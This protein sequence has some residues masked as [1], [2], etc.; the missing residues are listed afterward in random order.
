MR[1]KKYPQSHLVIS[2]SGKKLIIDP[3]Y[4]TF[5]KG[6]KVEDFQGADV[7]L[8]THQH[9]DHLG[10]ETIRDIVGDKP[11]LG[12]SDVIGK[13]KEIGV[14]NAN[15][16]SNMQE[17]EIGGF[18]IKAVD[19]PHFQKEGV[20]MPPNTGF[21]INGIFFHPGDGDKSPPITAPNAAVPIGG[22]TINYDTALE[23]IEGIGAKVVIPIHYDVY[24]GD[25]DEFKKMASNF[26]IDVRPLGYGEE[27]EI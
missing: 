7:Y 19:L 11:V 26:G 23:F 14:P 22:A 16:I 3:G 2:E 13:L 24:K 5:E 20:V 15:E 12:N 8:I 6:F 27:T 25:P 17:V 18:K 1:V 4:I 9:E 21:L 10:T